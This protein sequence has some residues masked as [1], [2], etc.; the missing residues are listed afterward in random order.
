MFNRRLI[1]GETIVHS[2]L[3]YSTSLGVVF[4]GPYRIFQTSLETQ[5]VTE[6]FNNWKN[7]IVRFSYHENSKNHR[8]AII[9]LKHKDNVFG[10]INYSF[11]KQLNIEIEYWRN[12][13]KRV[14]ETIKS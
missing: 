1:N 4:C 3:I 13:L 7:A 2:R 14:V 6:I 11:I 8:D 12:V 10:R 9:N 5:L